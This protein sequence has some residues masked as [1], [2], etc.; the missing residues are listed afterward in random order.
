MESN[1]YLKKSNWTK[2]ENQFDVHASANL[3]EVILFAKKQAAKRKAPVKFG[4]N[5]G[6]NDKQHKVNPNGS[7][8]FVD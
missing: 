6:P 7:I 8:E 2:D 3:D 1:R 5:R 4:F